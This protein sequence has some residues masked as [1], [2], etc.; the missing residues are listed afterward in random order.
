MTTDQ[1]IQL[2]NVVIA[3]ASMLIAFAALIR[4]KRTRDEVVQL[5]SQVS[6]QVQ[7]IEKMEQ[8]LQQIHLLGNLFGGGGGGVV[9]GEGGVATGGG[10]L[11]GRG[12]DIHM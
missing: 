5:K 10:G 9:Y 7:T 8:K 12:G 4:S 11:G 6:V 3:L 1:Y 2:A